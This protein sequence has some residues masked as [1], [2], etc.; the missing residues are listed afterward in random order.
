MLFPPESHFRARASRRGQKLDGRQRKTPFLEQADHPLPHGPTGPDDGNVLHRYLPPLCLKRDPTL[1]QDYRW[2]R[3]VHPVYRCVAR[4]CLAMPLLSW[5]FS[6]GSLRYVLTAG[7]SRRGGSGWGSAGLIALSADGV[8]LGRGVTSHFVADS[9]HTKL[10][11]NR[12]WI[13]NI[14]YC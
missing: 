4:S 14:D 3:K 2:A 9:A 5:V 11:P 10:T 7:K 6:L 13:F 8:Q 12:I 1:R